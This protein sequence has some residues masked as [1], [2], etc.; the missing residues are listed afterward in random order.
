MLQ[1]FDSDLLSLTLY[2]LVKL[3]FKIERFDTES[4][5]GTR[6]T[7]ML[8]LECPRIDTVNF[9]CVV[10]FNHQCRQCN[11]VTFEQDRSGRVLKY[12]P[13]T[14]QT[15]VLARDLFYPNGIAVA[16]DSSFL[17]LSFTSKTRYTQ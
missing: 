5:K 7:E 17:L 8:C 3:E 6:S 10:G 15:T 9:Y 4:V 1:F 12:D 13:E 16:Q 11:L 14:R 2:I